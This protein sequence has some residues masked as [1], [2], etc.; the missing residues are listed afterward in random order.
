MTILYRDPVFLRH[1]TQR[2][3]ECLERLVGIEQR[4]QNANL[5]G[6]CKPGTIQ[7][8]TQEQILRVH[9]QDVWESA[10]DLAANGGGQLDADTQ[11][12]PE[13]FNVA[14]AAAGTAAAAVDAVLDGRDTTALCLIRPP[15]HHATA[16][17]SMGFCLFNNIAVA[18][19]QAQARGVSRVLIVDWD[20]HHGN[21]TQ[22]IFYAEEQ[23]TFLSVHRFGM[24]FY[25]GT[26]AKQETGT[27]AGLGHT[28]NVP[29]DHDTTRKQYH[30][31]FLSALEDAAEACKPELVLISAG[32]DA[33]V[34]D[35]L[36]AFCLE[37]EDFGQLTTL[38]RQVAQT[39]AQGRVVSCLEGGYNLDALAASV[40]V[41]LEAL[42]HEGA[43]Q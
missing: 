40:Q 13:S 30:A 31:A 3:P 22:D 24:F 25:P 16:N 34:E 29:L 9:E 7:T 5:F 39:Y 11:V 42:L 41:H 6:R 10:R 27:G 12:S 37:T 14:L 20:V 35:P 33:H 38:I 18:A 4:L 26:G 36:G 43:G 17:Q 28:F 32:F 15:G 19:R 1:Q 23:I 2:H 21:G 8:A